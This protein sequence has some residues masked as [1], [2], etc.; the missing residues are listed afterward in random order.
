MFSVSEPHNHKALTGTCKGGNSESCDISFVDFCI[1]RLRQTSMALQLNLPAV[2]LQ[3]ITTAVEE[4][5]DRHLR[6][7][8]S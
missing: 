2:S 8:R 4:A 1:G 6:I 3:D 5:Y 7:A